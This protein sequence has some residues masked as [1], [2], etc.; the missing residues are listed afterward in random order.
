MKKKP[1][2]KKQTRAKKSY[3]RKKTV[4]TKQSQ[5]ASSQISSTATDA[6]A[7]AQPDYTNPVT[8]TAAI[9]DAIT[10]LHNVVE[11]IQLANK[12][13]SH[14]LVV[15]V[16]TPKGECMA[17]FGKA[18]EL[19]KTMAVLNTVVNKAAMENMYPLEDIFSAKGGSIEYMPQG[20]QDIFKSLKE[21]EKSTGGK[22]AVVGPF[23]VGKTQQDKIN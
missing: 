5:A 11:A 3:S 18:K 20:L 1:V 23:N 6:S 12:T 17:H 15:A 16:A 22:V 4:D 21:L 8:A 2:T 13:Q 14:T 9:E 10:K 7:Q 19:V